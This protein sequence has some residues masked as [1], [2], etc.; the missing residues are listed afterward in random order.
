MKLFRTI[1]CFLLLSAFAGSV[2]HAGSCKNNKPEDNPDA[3]YTVHED[4]TVTDTRT[5]LMWKR[6]SEGQDWNGRFCNGRLDSLNLDQ[7]LALAEAHEFAG[8]SDW[9]VPEEAELRSLL[10]FCRDNPTINTTIFSRTPSWN[11]VT[12]TNSS[13][14]PDKI[15]TVS[16]W[17][18]SS[19]AERREGKSH[20]RLVRGGQ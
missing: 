18:G 15:V 19:V 9:R 4:G 11:F 10:E 20:V 17:Y 6:C 5:H 3:I 13:Q 12:R 1:F 16:F 7:A 8:Y 14:D 2:A